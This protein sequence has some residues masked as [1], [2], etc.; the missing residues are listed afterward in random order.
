ML[1]S[2]TQS[3]NNHLCFLLPAHYHTD[4]LDAATACPGELEDEMGPGL[5]YF[6]NLTFATM[7]ITA[8][9]GNV[10]V[11]YIVVSKELSNI[12]RDNIEFLIRCNSNALSP[13]SRNP[14]PDYL[15]L[16][17]CFLKLIYYVKVTS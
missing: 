7:I 15:D 9:L 10:A 14:H 3:S 12:C 13:P 1:L 5:L 11:L 17:K 6:W 8:I 16:L 4:I 2:L